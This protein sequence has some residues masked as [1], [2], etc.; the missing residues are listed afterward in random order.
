[1][2]STPRELSP[3]ALSP[4]AED[5]LGWP[6]L[7]AVYRFDYGLEPD[8]R[9]ELRDWIG[10]VHQPDGCMERGSTA[11]ITD[12]PAVEVSVLGLR[13]TQAPVGVAFAERGTETSS[14]DVR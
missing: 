5:E 8:E 4:Q 2:G 13:G 14:C 1:V 11:W 3:P 6:A 7:D 12:R 9:L 10:L